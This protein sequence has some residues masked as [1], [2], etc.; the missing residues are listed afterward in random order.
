MGKQHEHDIPTAAPCSFTAE[1]KAFI[2]ELAAELLPHWQAAHVKSCPWGQRLK[3]YV[4]IGT[5]VAVC[6]ALLGVRNV[7]DLFHWLWLAR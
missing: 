3:K 2:R 5:G 1:Q 6:L 7:P 4:Y